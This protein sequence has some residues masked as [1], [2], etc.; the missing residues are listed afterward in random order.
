MAKRGPRSGS[1]MAEPAP[2]PR[3]CDQPGCPEPG[4]YRAP[5][6][7][8][9]LNDYKWFCLA[10]VRAYNAAWDFYKGLGPAEIEH[11]I[12]SDTSTLPCCATRSACSPTRP[13]RT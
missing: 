1:F 7:R 5:A 13:M 10:H 12:R 3:P 6:D 4:E 11:E 9:R 2:P 8:R